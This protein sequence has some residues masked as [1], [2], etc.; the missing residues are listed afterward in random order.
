MLG[1]TNGNDIILPALSNPASTSE[2][3]EGYQAIDGEGNL[4]TGMAAGGVSY[5]TT[6]VPMGSTSK[7]QV[8]NGK[9]LF[10]LYYEVATSSQFAFFNFISNSGSSGYGDSRSGGTSGSYDENTKTMSFNTN[11]P[12]S[13]FT[14]GTL[15]ILSEV[16]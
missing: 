8:L 7:S 9:P 16:E 12:S 11:I 3:L 15:V 5:E 6:I 14:G 4:L 13:Y 2:I 1:N 10:A